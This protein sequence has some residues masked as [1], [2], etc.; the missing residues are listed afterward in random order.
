V[1][2]AKDPTV[3][4]APPLEPESF[5]GDLGAGG[6]GITHP[7]LSPT[8]LFPQMPASVILTHGSEIVLPQ[9]VTSCAWNAPQASAPRATCT[10]N[11]PLITDFRARLAVTVIIAIKPPALLVRS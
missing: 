2:E 11:P 4:S 8:A 10:A 5:T 1:I 3:P 6:K 9:V 7:I